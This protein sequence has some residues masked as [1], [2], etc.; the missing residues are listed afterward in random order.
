MKFLQLHSKLSFKYCV[1]QPSSTFQQQGSTAYNRVGFLPCVSLLSRSAHKVYCF[2]LFR[3]QRS[4]RHQAWRHYFPERELSKKG[5]RPKLENAT[6]CDN[7]RL[8]FSSLVVICFDSTFMFAVGFFSKALLSL[9]WQRESNA[10]HGEEDSVHQWAGSWASHLTPA[11]S[12]G[13]RTA[14]QQG[15]SHHLRLCL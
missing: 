14:E 6:I 8:L 3:L 10:T 12:V 1:L 11:R 15:P 7:S 4:K 5:K 13:S 2:L 9:R